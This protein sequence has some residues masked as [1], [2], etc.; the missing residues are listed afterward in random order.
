MTKTLFS[1]ALV[2][3]CFALHA[4]TEEK[5]NKRFTVQSG[6]K[7]VVDVDFGSVD[8]TTN[9]GGAMTVDVFRKVTRASKSDEE[10]FLRERPVTFAQDGNTVT[11]Q[12]RAKSR[13]IGFSFGRQRTEGK[14]TITVPAQF[15]AQIKT[16]GGGITV[17]DLTGEVKAG[18]SGGGLKFTRLHGPLDGGT[19]GG[20]IH[21]MDCKGALQVN[22]S[23]G[24]IN[25]SGGSGSLA[26]ET[27]GGSVGVKDFRGPVHVETSG[28]GISI[29]DVAG[30]VEG[31]TSGGSISARFSSKPVNEVKLETS[32]G[33]VTVSVPAD[34]A[35]DL[36]AA[37]SGGRVSSDLPVS[38]T[39][40]PSR[41]HLKGPVNG[42]GK[43]V[44][45]RTSG[46]S[47]H[48]KKM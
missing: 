37:T 40:K 41:S 13:N 16:S 23:G 38:T 22:T 20:S 46:G 31:S 27:S 3:G 47:I 5:I 9:A 36:D 25:V 2:A 39:G 29:E 10:E 4:E 19:S 24:G 21:V 11:I 14:Y 43:A 35:F 48:V 26:G 7:L 18:T 17:S 45:L 12:S 44:L 6:G 28:G 33:G 30:K 15:N 1:V 34:S 8:V 32:G 42:G